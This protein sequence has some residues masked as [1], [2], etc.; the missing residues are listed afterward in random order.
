M[1]TDGTRVFGEATNGV[2]ESEASLYA[3][4]SWTSVGTIPNG[5]SCG[6]FTSPYHEV[7]VEYDAFQVGFDALK[8]HFGG[9]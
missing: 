7:P 4:G 6:S 1:S 5:S 9:A 3:L 2:G 8:R